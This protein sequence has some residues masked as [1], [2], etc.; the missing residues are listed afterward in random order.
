MV[1]I[2]CSM[3]DSYTKECPL[4][5]F[6]YATY[7]NNQT[8]PEKDETP[9]NEVSETINMTNTV[10]TED[11]ILFGQCLNGAM[12]YVNNKEFNAD[13]PEYIKQLNTA[14]SVIYEFAKEKRKTTL[15][16]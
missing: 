7:K 14:F 9:K 8:K 3:H 5:K 4:C 15:G 12:Q 16:K 10:N 1:K 13:H 6:E 2:H 11:K